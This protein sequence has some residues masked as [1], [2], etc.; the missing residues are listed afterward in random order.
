MT[1]RLVWIANTATY[2]SWLTC[3]HTTH[4]NGRPAVAG[5]GATQVGDA[6]YCDACAVYITMQLDQNRARMTAL[7]E[8]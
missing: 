8:P 6:W 1:N 5:E 2:P 4:G 7:L 3:G